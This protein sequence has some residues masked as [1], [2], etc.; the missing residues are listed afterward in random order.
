MTSSAGAQIP[1]TVVLPVLNEERNLAAALESVRWSPQVIVVDSGSTDRTVAIAQSFGAQVVQFHYDGSGPKKKNWA[2]RHLDFA[3]EWVLLL[4]AD[5]RVPA[6]LRDEIARAVAADEADGY[7]LDRD[8][9]FMGRSLRCFRPNWNMRLFR[10]RR[11]VFEDLGLFNLPGTGDNEIH[12]HVLIDGRAA[13]LHEPLLH[14][15]HDTLSQWLERHN[16]Y[17]TWEAHLYR[18]FRSEPVGAG[19]RDLL[20]MNAFQRR[21][22]LRRIWVR[23]PGRPVLRFLLFYGWRRGFL[24]GRAGFVYS[25]L[26]GYYEFI[27]GLKIGEIEMERMQAH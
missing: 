6:A 27:I 17:A 10:H 9:H 25:V 18:R 22:A 4:D 23:L 5:E 11:G 7:Y 15:D 19:P 3:H 1:V 2:L 21:R 13:F 24:D 26:M 20:R 8:L 14:D 16:R 12:E